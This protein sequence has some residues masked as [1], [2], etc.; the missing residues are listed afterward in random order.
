MSP[1]QALMSQAMD[2]SR[3]RHAEIEAELTRV[4][5]NVGN[6]AGNKIAKSWFLLLGGGGRLSS[7]R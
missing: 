3:T 1:Q 2:P 6:P 5:K 7:L 4:K